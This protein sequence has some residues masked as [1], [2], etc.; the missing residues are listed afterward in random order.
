MIYLD[1]LRLDPL[2]RPAI[3]GSSD[4]CFRTC[5]SVCPYVRSNS[6]K[7]KQPKTMITTGETVGLAAWIIDDTCLLFYVFMK[8]NLFLL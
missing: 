1:K 6:S 5:P 8:K 4:H 2:G 7:T 3:T